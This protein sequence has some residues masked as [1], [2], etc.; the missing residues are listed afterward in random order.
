MPTD[1]DRIERILV[2]AHGAADPVQLDWAIDNGKHET[3]NA[4]GVLS[5]TLVT[6]VLG[7]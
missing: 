3:L 6:R 5:G 7:A 2:D 4:L 1:R